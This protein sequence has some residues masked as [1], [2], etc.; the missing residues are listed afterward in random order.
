M[1][2]KTVGL[3]QND[4]VNQQ[5]WNDLTKDILRQFR[6]GMLEEGIAKASLIDL[7]YEPQTVTYLLQRERLRILE[8]EME[9]IA[10]HVEKAYKAGIVDYALATER[11]TRA[12][13]V[14]SAANRMVYL[15]GLDLQ[16]EIELA[17]VP[18]RTATVSKL[19]DWFQEGVI[20]PEEYDASLRE[21]NYT[22]ETRRRYMTE[23]MV[24]WMKRNPNT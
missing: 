7:G 13:F 14:A 23:Q 22:E 12:G 16:N 5:A 4:K 24:E 18:T 20:S 3:E 2:S 19:G 17:E 11:L 9:Q 21:K 6:N 15:W 1:L 10:G 8:D